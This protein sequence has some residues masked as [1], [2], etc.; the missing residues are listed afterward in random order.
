M[1]KSNLYVKCTQNCFRYP[2]NDV[3]LKG[4][5]KKLVDKMSVMVSGKVFL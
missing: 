3:I 2:I 4:G 1:D 5:K